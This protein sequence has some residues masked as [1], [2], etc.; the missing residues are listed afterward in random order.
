MYI[1]TVDL[2]QFNVILITTINFDTLFNFKF[3]NYIIHIY[4]ILIP[5]MR[6]LNTKSLNC[7]IHAIVVN[8]TVWYFSLFAG[9]TV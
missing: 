2:N 9:L 7:I 1:L 5:S 8:L 4:V 3:E 6:M